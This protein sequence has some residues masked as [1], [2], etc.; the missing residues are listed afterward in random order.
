MPK[1]TCI[2]RDHEDDSFVSYSGS[3]VTE[4]SFYFSQSRGGCTIWVGGALCPKKASGDLG[5]LLCCAVLNM[6]LP[7]LGAQLLQLSLFPGSRAGE[8]D[9]NKW[10]C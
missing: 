9:K 6:G 4:V 10:L 2:N 1:A 5:G 3:K 7:P 8:A